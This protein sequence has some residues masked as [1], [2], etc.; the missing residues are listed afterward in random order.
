MSGLEIKNKELRKQCFEFIKF[1]MGIFGTSTTDYS[2]D[3]G[4]CTQLLF[5]LYSLSCVES[6]MIERSSI[7][8][9]CLLYS[10]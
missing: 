8:T 5:F 4:L 9:L 7:I 3:I 6:D 10:I 2:A 1:Q